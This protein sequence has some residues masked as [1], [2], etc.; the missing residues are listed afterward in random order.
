MSRVARAL[1]LAIAGAVIAPA[2]TPVPALGASG[3]AVRGQVVVSPITIELVISPSTAPAGTWVT[4]RATVRNLGPATIAKVAVRLRA[5]SGVV[6]RPTTPKLVRSLGPGASAVV[7]WSLCG[8]RPGADLVFAEATFGRV[9][10]DSTA[11]LLTVTAGGG[12]CGPA[13][14]H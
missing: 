6:L 11:R 5:P 12:G 2:P 14:G 3:A 7:A 13:S 8:R 9:V 1:A 10:I 4:A